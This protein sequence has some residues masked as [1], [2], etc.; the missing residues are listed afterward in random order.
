MFCL[1]LCIYGNQD[2]GFNAKGKLD[3]FEKIK[4]EALGE[5][6]GDCSSD[7]DDESRKEDESLDDTQSVDSLVMDATTDPVELQR[8]LKE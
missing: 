8:Q 3:R 4:A 1:N 7:E 6:K 2:L 5:V